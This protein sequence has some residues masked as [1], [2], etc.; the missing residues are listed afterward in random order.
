[1]KDSILKKYPD[2]FAKRASQVIQAIENIDSNQMNNELSTLLVWI[3]CFH[4]TKTVPIAA[5]NRWHA[6]TFYNQDPLW[7]YQMDIDEEQ[8]LEKLFA[9]VANAPANIFDTAVFAELFETQHKPIHSLP[10]QVYTQTLPPVLFNAQCFPALSEIKIRNN[11]MD[12]IP[13]EVFDF[14]A[15]EYLHIYHGSIKELSPKIGQLTQLKELVIKHNKLTKLPKTLAQLPNLVHLNVEDNQLSHIDQVIYSKLNIG[16]IHLADNALIEFPESLDSYPPSLNNW[17][18]VYKHLTAWIEKTYNM[19]LATWWASKE[20][21]STA[22]QAFAL[23]V[24]FFLGQSKLI[25]KLPKDKSIRALLNPPQPYNKFEQLLMM[26]ALS[27]Q[28]AFDS[29][30]FQQLFHHIFSIIETHSLA[31]LEKKYDLAFSIQNLPLEALELFDFSSQLLPYLKEIDASFLEHDNPIWVKSLTQITSLDLRNQKLS[32]VPHALL[33]LPNLKELKLDNNNITF[34]PAEIHQLSKLEVLTLTRN[35]LTELPAEI[36]LLPQLKTL[37][38]SHNQLKTFPQD[39]FWLPQLKTFEARYNHIEAWPLMTGVPVHQNLTKIFLNNNM[40]THLPEA[41]EALPKLQT[42]DVSHNLLI[43]LPDGLETLSKLKILEI[44]HNHLAVLPAYLQQFGLKKGFLGNYFGMLDKTFEQKCLE[45]LRNAPKRLSSQELAQV[46]CLHFFFPKVQ[47]RNLAGD[48]L[49]NQQ[50]IRLFELPKWPH[51]KPYFAPLVNFFIQLYI[52]KPTLDWQ[53]FEAWITQA[54]KAINTDQ[55]SY[56]DKFILNLIHK[57]PEVPQLTWEQIDC[58][59]TNFDLRAHKK[60]D[61]EEIITFYQQVSQLD[62]TADW[63][64]LHQWAIKTGMLN[65]KKTEALKFAQA[66]TKATQGFDESQQAMVSRWVNSVDVRITHKFD[67]EQFLELLLEATHTNPLLNWVA[68]DDWLKAVDALSSKRVDYMQFLIKLI[69]SS[70]KLPQLNWEML[71]DWL[72]RVEAISNKKRDN[73][74]FLEVL[75]KSNNFYEQLDETMLESWMER[76]QI[77]SSKPMDLQQ[78]FRQKF[79]S[80]IFKYWKNSSV[81]LTGNALPAIPQGLAQNEKLESLDLSLN[82]IAHIPMEDTH[83]I[84]KVKELNLAYNTFEDF[85]PHL[86]DCKKLERLDLSHNQLQSTLPVVANKLPRLTYLNLSFNRFKTFP[87]EETSIFPKLLELNL[88][89]N[90]LLTVPEAISE[91]EFLEILDLSYNRLGDFDNAFQEVYPYALPLKISFLENL[92][93][94]YLQHNGLQQLPP[95]IGLVENLQVLDCNNNRFKEF[96]VEI[97]ESEKLEV[98]NFA[99][100]QITYIPPGIQYMTELRQLDLSGNPLTAYEVRKIQQLIPQVTIVFDEYIPPT[101]KVMVPDSFI[102]KPVPETAPQQ[103]IN[104]DDI[105]RTLANI[106]REGNYQLLAETALPLSV[107][108]LQ[109]KLVNYWLMVAALSGNSLAQTKLGEFVIQPHRN[110]NQDQVVYWY[111]LAAQQ[112]HY[113]SQVKLAQT[114]RHGLGMNQNTRYAIYW[115]QEAAKQGYEAAL[116]ELA[117]IY[118]KGEGI[119]RDYIK[120]FYWYEKLAEKGNTDA[121]LKLAE[122]YR[123]GLGVKPNIGA[124][125]VLYQALEQQDKEVDYY[126]LAQGYELGLGVP[127]DDQKAFKYFAKSADRGNLEGQFKA[128][129]LLLNTTM[130]SHAIDWL[131]QAAEQKH[132]KAQKTLGE[133]YFFGKKVSF[134]VLE[135]KKW[136]EMAAQS[137]DAE[138]QYKM[139]EIFIQGHNAVSVK[140]S[141]AKE[142]F[143]KAAAQDYEPAKKRLGDM[144]ANGWGVSKDEAK[145]GYWYSQVDS[146]LLTE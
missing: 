143:E 31:Q 107:Y 99:H 71:N 76:M 81:N 45:T 105:K 64:R 134:N 128:G 110:L 21:D 41:W 50:Q 40:L 8:R 61:F 39:I 122:F 18:E 2:L 58:W 73:L 142:W 101:F 103:I 17:L 116:E 138:S 57:I 80:F 82:M 113:Q 37:K 36:G 102:S 121:Q 51:H 96:P 28:Q 90:Y 100:N 35:Q 131:K 139:G 24:F 1:M 30:L 75:F 12:K 95:G 127:Q 98:L 115:Y 141:V 7:S 10:P 97:C 5:Y 66:L 120:A 23:F 38:V 133:L 60:Y 130:T 27:Q 88:S 48:V 144:Y 54:G 92:T 55:R 11:T 43:S 77:R 13:E 136:Y 91:L 53:V 89:F 112:G 79:P 44:N 72:I 124:A 20:I 114:Y 32:S 145:A 83:S 19:P 109:T 129:K 125:A 29:R 68:L 33:R 47:V 52:Q 9:L 146:D 106:A 87:L 86:L 123:D 140:Y 117:K 104:K 119:E 25:E 62:P 15:L 132:L 74:E 42:L 67:Y 70:A 69:E 56:V 65:P 46:I 26:E 94:L 85:P 84:E 135:A 59:I 6:H 34:L 22:K 118:E 16:T 63:Q 111:T 4:K 137:G 49:Q 93:H 78:L 3:T 126:T 14:Q 108:K